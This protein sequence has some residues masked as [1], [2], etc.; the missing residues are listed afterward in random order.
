MATSSARERLED[1]AVGG[2]VSSASP[3]RTS[4][5]PAMRV[6]AGVLAMAALAA[7]QCTQSFLNATFDLSKLRVPHGT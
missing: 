7:S 6:L 2:K 5:A 3:P 4:V 1:S